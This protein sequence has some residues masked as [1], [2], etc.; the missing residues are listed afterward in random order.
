M[1]DDFVVRT[2]SWSIPE[3]LDE[4]IDL[5]HPTTMFRSK[6]RA[7]AATFR[8][9]DKGPGQSTVAGIPSSEPL[10][11]NPSCNTTITP[12]CL[13]EL[14]NATQYKVQAPQKSKI[15]ISSYL[16]NCC[17]LSKCNRFLIEYRGICKH[18]GSSTILQFTT[19][20]SSRYIVYRHVS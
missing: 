1:S 8:L 19:A 16:G 20:R 7:Q 3:F 12:T 15:A 17:V 4:H 14:Y 18:P 5:V 13:F 10:A 2:T 11:V 9:S 6:I